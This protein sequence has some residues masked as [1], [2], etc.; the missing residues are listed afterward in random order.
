MLRIRMY[1]LVFL[2][3]DH[4]WPHLHLLASVQILCLLGILV[5]VCKLVQ[6]HGMTHKAELMLGERTCVSWEVHCFVGEVESFLEKVLIHMTSDYEVSGTVWFIPQALTPEM[7]LE[8]L[9]WAGRSADKRAEQWA[10][11]FMFS[12]SL[13]STLEREDSNFWFI[14][15]Q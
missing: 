6:P 12:Q 7:R 10:H 11:K 5:S 14:G 15:I 4:R 13:P 8:G 9:P 3:T 2:S 1:S